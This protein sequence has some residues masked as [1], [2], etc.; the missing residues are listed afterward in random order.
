[1]K[2]VFKVILENPEISLDVWDGME[3]IIRATCIVDFYGKDN[4]PLLD[5]EIS[6]KSIH[7]RIER[8]LLKQWG[9]REWNFNHISYYKPLLKALFPYIREEIKGYCLKGYLPD[10]IS[11]HFSTNG[12]PSSFPPDDTALPDLAGAIVKTTYKY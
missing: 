1:M 4:E 10:I 2:K 5:I 7:I 8:T 6:D 11:V 12:L 9:F 3:F